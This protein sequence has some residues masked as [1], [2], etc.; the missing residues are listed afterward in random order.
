M[1]RASR[2]SVFVLRTTMA[3]IFAASV[4]SPATC[5]V[6]VC[7]SHRTNVMAPASFRRARSPIGSIA[8]VRDRSHDISDQAVVPSRLGGAGSDEDDRVRLV[9]I[10]LLP[11]IWVHLEPDTPEEMS[12]LEACAARGEWTNGR[13]EEAISTLTT[14]A[15][16]LGSPVGTPERRVAP[17]LIVV[18]RGDR[19]LYERLAGLARGDGAVIWDR[20][21]QERRTT[22]RAMP[23]ERRRED[24]RQPPPETWAALGFM[25][26]HEPPSP[27]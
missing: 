2:R 12:G 1:C 3:R 5:C 11:N 19:P 26:V 20:R 21:E 24:R 6:R 17:W 4:S 18:R 7:R 8:T 23:A 15:D 25:M 13:G 22:A 16:R 27:P 10:G 14:L 9:I